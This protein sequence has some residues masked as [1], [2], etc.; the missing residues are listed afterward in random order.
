VGEEVETVHKA[1]AM[2]RG[3]RKSRQYPCGNNTVGCAGLRWL[4]WLQAFAVRVGER[5]DGAELCSE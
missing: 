5:I 4:R 3:Q 2:N 1:Q